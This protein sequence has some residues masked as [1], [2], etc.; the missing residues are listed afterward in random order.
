MRPEGG[1]DDKEVVGGVYGMDS[2][3][4]EEQLG[5]AVGAIGYV[6]GSGNRLATS[7]PSEVTFAIDTR[8]I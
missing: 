1:S 5:S 8:R 2:Q 3:E 4:E 6:R 7:I